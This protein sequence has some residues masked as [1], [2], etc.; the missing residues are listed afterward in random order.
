[1]SCITKLAYYFS[2]FSRIDS[3]GEQ[4]SMSPMLKAEQH[5]LV[6][7]S[8]TPNSPSRHRSSRPRTSDK[9]KHKKKVIADTTND[10]SSNALPNSDTQSSESSRDAVKHKLTK[11]SYKNTSDRRLAKD[12]S[13]VAPTVC[14]DDLISAYSPIVDRQRHSSSASSSGPTRPTSSPS[15]QSAERPFGFHHVGA[16]ISPSRRSHS[17]SI[18]SPFKRTPDMSSSKQ[19]RLKPANPSSAKKLLD[20]SP[21]QSTSPSCNSDKKLYVVTSHGVLCT[22]LLAR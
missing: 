8:S 21:Q 9:S 19:G 15:R 18:L 4:L 14:K 1:M 7:M 3:S 6:S 16:C 2:S 17:S 20:F 11:S 13:T 22:L 5:H 10:H 12:S